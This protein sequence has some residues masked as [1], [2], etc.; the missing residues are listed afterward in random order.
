MS[1][2]SARSTPAVEWTSAD[3]RIPVTRDSPSASAPKISERCEIDLSPGTRSSPAT[4]RQT[5]HRSQASSAVARV[6]LLVAVL[7]DHRR[8]EREPLLGAPAAFDR[9]RAGHDDRAA[10]ESPAAR[11]RV[12]A[13]DASR[14]TRSNTGVP[15]VRMTPAASTARD[16]NDRALVDAA[17][18]ADEHVVLDDDRRRVHRLEHAADL[19]RRAQVH[20]LADLRARADE[21][22]RI[23]HRP[24]V[25]I[26]A[27]VHVHRR[28]A[29]HARREVRAAAHRRAA[30]HD[31]HAVVAASNARGG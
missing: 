1:T 12:R 3:S 6:G 13:I 27:D 29:H 31:A 10:R 9:A 19:R 18:A 11:P 23:D 30:R 26:R 15:R 20:A 4:C 14:C 17:V 28:H 22:V 7:H 2:P 24:A 21:R 25:D 8:L 16:A 5:C